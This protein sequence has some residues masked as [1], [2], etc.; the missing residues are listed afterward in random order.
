VEAIA[1]TEPEARSD[2]GSLTTGAKRVNGGFVLNGQKVFCSN[3]HISDNIFVV[4]RSTRER[5]S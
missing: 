1:M 4:A 3:G 5:T 2:V